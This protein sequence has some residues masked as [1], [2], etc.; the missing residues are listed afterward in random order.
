MLYGFT[1]MWC[2][3]LTKSQRQKIEQRLTGAGE[4]EEGVLILIGYRV[5]VRDDEKTLGIDMVM[6]T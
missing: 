6:V 5:F 1:C 2:L 3:E 4:R